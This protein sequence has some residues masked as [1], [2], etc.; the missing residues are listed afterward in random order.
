MAKDISNI[1]LF[2]ALRNF[3]FLPCLAVGV[4]KG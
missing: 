3:Y 2:F 1:F 4:L